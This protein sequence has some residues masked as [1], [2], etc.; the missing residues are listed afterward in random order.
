MSSSAPRRLF[1]AAIS[2]LQAVK[3]LS[4]N[5]V[6]MIAMRCAGYERVDLKACAEYGIKVARVPTYSPTSVAEHAVALLFAL[7]R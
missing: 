4:Q 2:C 7:N 3:K 6:K 1:S 5:G